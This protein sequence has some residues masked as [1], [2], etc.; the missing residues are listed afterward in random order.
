MPAAVVG[1]EFRE[2]ERSSGLKNRAYP[3]EDSAW[4]SE[5][6]EGVDCNSALKGVPL[7]SFAEPLGFTDRTAHRS[8]VAVL[9]D[10]TLGFPDRTEVAV[11][12]R[13]GAPR[14]PACHGERRPTA[15]AA[16]IQHAAPIAD[17]P[18][19]EQFNGAVNRA[20]LHGAAAGSRWGAAP[21]T[22]L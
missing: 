20:R 22:G 9:S 4:I 12:G 21:R 7:K 15:A 2:E 8:A 5:V 1:R 3:L 19:Q 16:D 11:N 18:R 14:P 13:N 6:M 10:E 17:V